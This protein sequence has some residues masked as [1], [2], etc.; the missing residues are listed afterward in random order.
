MILV[1]FFLFREGGGEKRE[2]E[3]RQERQER[4]EGREGREERRE[5][6]RNLIN[7]L[8]GLN[9]IIIRRERKKGFRQSRQKRLFKKK[10]K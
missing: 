5:R 4:G 1:F 9:K 8:I 6:K 2:R 7:K 3:E 10:K